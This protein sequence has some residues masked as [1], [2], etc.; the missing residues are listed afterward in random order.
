[1]G[2]QELGASGQIPQEEGACLQLCTHQ[3][4]REAEENRQVTHHTPKTYPRPLGQSLDTSSLFLVCN[5][6]ELPTCAGGTRVALLEEPDPVIWS[7][8]EDGIT[9]TAFPPGVL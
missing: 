6:F 5:R 2:E 9:K 7:E 4:T 3:V 8:L 1:M